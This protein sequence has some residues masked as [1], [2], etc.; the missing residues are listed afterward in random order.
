MQANTS[1]AM[2]AFSDFPA[3]ADHPLHP[4]AELVHAYLRAYAERFGVI[5]CVRFGT[6]VS[7]VS[8]GRRVDGE[9]FDA[10]VVASGRFR[11]PHVPAALRRFTGEL[12][13]AFDYPG[14]VPFQGRRVLVVGNG[15]SGLE[16]ASDLAAG[17]SVVS[18]FRKPRY[19]IR[20]NVGGVSSDWQWYTMFGALER[21]LLPRETLART[22]RERVV[23][24]AGDPADHGAPRPDPDILVAGLSLCRSG[25]PRSPAGVSPA[26]RRSPR[27]T[28]A[29]SRSPRDPETFDV[30]VCHRLRPR[31]PLPRRRP[32]ARARSRPRPLSP[33][34]APGRARHGFVGQFLAQGPYLPLLELQARWIVAVLAG[35]VPPPDPVRMRHAI[36]QPRPPL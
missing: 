15:I 17:A 33:H 11:R 24:V 28:A 35:A 5:G 19:V 23:G 7:E 21:R 30:L 26:A 25:S 32:A 9:P 12:L 4:S 29:R 3:P 14:A 2:T 6:A 22:L 27:S 1:R 16:I 31:R 36:A 13:H 20:K 10:V 18:A 8:A 34:A